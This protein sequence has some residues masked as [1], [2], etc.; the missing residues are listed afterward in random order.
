M[1]GDYLVV[2]KTAYAFGNRPARG[3]MAVFK[4][5]TNSNIDYVK[6]VVGMPGDRI[7]MIH[8]ILNINGLPV[9]LEKVQLAPDFY[10]D[11][12]ATY[13]RETL[14]NGRS[15]VV[16]DTLDD[17]Q[18]DNTEVYAVPEGHYFT[19]GDHRDNSQDSRHLN[20][21]G[22]VPEESFIG[23]VVFGF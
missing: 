11:G 10:R 22:Y 12:P 21:V 18:A 13:Y 7:Q 3:D 8:E 6:R 19:L 9:K 5:P 14:P 16:A 23:P 4:L 15:Y 1:V 2:S 20:V 17:G